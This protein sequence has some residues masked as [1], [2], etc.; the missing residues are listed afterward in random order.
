MR[1]VFSAIRDRLAHSIPVIQALGG[2]RRV[3]FEQPTMGPADEAELC[4][5]L[6]IDALT[7]EQ[8]VKCDQFLESLA[9]GIADATT[10]AIFQGAL[11]G[12]QKP[13]LVK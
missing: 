1:S 9:D 7:P 13:R 12:S 10:E 6:G 8:R 4:R 2:A 11:Y 3:K 5:I